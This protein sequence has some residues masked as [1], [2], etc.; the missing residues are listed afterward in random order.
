MLVSELEK[1]AEK[2]MSAAR[3]LKRRP[4]GAS[5]KAGDNLYYGRGRILKKNPVPGKSLAALQ[6]QFEHQLGAEVGEHQCGKSG[7]GEAHRGLAAPAELGVAP[8]QH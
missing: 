7:N 4:K 2:R 1:K 6:Y 5:S 8:Q 3:T